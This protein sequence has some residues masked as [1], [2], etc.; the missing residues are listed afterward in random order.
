MRSREHKQGGVIEKRLFYIDLP[1]TFLLLSEESRI[2]GLAVNDTTGKMYDAFPPLS[3]TRAI[4]IGFDA[5]AAVVYWTDSGRK[6]IMKSSLIVNVSTATTVVPA[7]EKPEDVAVDWAGQYVFYTDTVLK[8]IG[9]ASLDGYFATW[10][11][12]SGLDKPRA[13]ALDPEDG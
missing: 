7:L 1:P 3:V 4:G 13:I 8:R 9:M 12:E 6:A 2:R 10:V 11:I 5:A